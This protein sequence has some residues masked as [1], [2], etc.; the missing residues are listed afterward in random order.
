MSTPAEQNHQALAARWED[1]QHVA[2]WGA[3]TVNE[4]AEND[5]QVRAIEEQMDAAWKAVQAERYGEPPATSVAEACAAVDEL[6]DRA[7]PASP[8]RHRGDVDHSADEPADC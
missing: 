1:A 3:D 5:A 6:R 8:G 4:Q 2:G 7:E